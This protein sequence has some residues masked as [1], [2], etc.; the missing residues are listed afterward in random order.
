MLSNRELT[1]GT[2]QFEAAGTPLLWGRPPIIFMVV[3]ARPVGPEVG[4]GT[5][6]QDRGWRVVSTLAVA[7]QP[8]ELVAAGV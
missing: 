3:L 7:N 5:M 1:R 2:F 8:L 6:A 4:P